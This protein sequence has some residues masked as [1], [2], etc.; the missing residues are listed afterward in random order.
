MINSI[1]KTGVLNKRIIVGRL[2][3][4]LTPG[5]HCYC[6][7][8]HHCP[9]S[10][11]V[12][13]SH[14]MFIPLPGTYPKKPKPTKICIRMLIFVLFTVVKKQTGDNLSCIGQVRLK[15]FGHNNIMQFSHRK[16]ELFNS[17]LYTDVDISLRYLHFTDQVA[18]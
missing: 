5:K 18:E 15:T 1:T 14:Q 12:S 2:E 16:F 4:G 7:H 11:R 6:H 8:H 3:H 9:N 13:F 10:R 17:S